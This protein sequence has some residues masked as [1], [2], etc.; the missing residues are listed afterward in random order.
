MS[1]E[2]CPECG[3]KADLLI[4]EKELFCK[5][6]VKMLKHQKLKPHA[7]EVATLSIEEKILDKR[8][9]KLRDRKNDLIKNY[10]KDLDSKLVTIDDV[11]YMIRLSTHGD[12]VELS[13]VEEL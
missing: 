5:A 4:Y 2:I 12:R 11:K 9:S 1:L 13:E 7:E 6:C 8:L 10:G 3:E